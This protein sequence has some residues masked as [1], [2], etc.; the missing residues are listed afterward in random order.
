MGHEAG[1]V[2]ALVLTGVSRPEALAVSP[3]QPDFVLPSIRQLPGL[4]E[5]LL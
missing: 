1:M 3:I 2:T 5:L 4:L